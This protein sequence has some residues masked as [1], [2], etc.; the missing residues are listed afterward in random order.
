MKTRIL[1]FLSLVLCT[2]YISFAQDLYPTSDKSTGKYG[3]KIKDQIEWVLPPVYAKASHFDN[4]LAIVSDGQSEFAIN[5]HGERVSPKFKSLRKTIGINPTPYWGQDSTGI[6]KIY[7]AKFEPL[8]DKSFQ[9]LAAL[10]GN[11][12]RFKADNG[13]YGCMDY[14]GNELVP[15]IYKEI[16][17]ENYYY[18][19]GYKKCDK[20]GLE[21]DSFEFLEV[22]DENDQYGAITLDNQI[23]IPLKYKSGYNVKYKAAKRYYSKTIK[24]Y[25]LSPAKTAIDTKIRQA[26]EQIKASDREL[27]ALYPAD[28]PAVEKTVVKSIGESY[29]FFKGEKQ[30]SESYDNIGENAGFYFVEAYGKMGI[31]NAIG[32]KIIPC[33]YDLIDIWNPQ[34]KN[35]I[36]LVKKDDKY[37]L[38]DAEGK[39]LTKYDCDMISSPT[40]GT[41]LA[42]AQDLYWLINPYGRIVSPR[43]YQYIDNYSTEGKIYAELYGY[44]TE[45][46][47]D[48]K[49]VSPILK[50]IFDEAYNIP[51]S[52]D[53]QAKYDKYTLCAAL[54]DG[55]RTGYRALSLNNIGALFEDLGDTDKAMTYYTQARDLGN[56]TARKNVRRIRTDRALDALQQVGDA[57]SQAAQ[58]IDTSNTYANLQPTEM[59]YGT[60][61]SET[62]TS[63][64][65]ST[66]KKRQQNDELSKQSRY[67]MTSYRTD[68][69]T[70]TGW[71]DQLRDM[72]LN[73][74][75]FTHLSHDQFCRTVKDIQRRMKNLREKIVKNGG[76]RGK[77]TLEDWNPC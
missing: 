6:Y 29:A 64:S 46:T 36:F 3:Y 44:K 45:L 51:M 31:C 34:D 50:Q 5:T 59:D 2:A 14:M 61:T 39:D 40:N 73:P 38:F 20:D 9:E 75:R 19:I 76:T 8:C 72:K 12:F 7:N 68:S 58:T 4:R 74:E 1:T 28:L 37:R 16:T 22:C 56:E 23:L 63:S 48:G 13:L 18:G 24:P 27:T 15:P 32:D 66:G 69:W 21:S 53:L 26:V 71:E 55:N 52:G 30:V 42:I 47:K 70:Y 43:G 62:G 57:L 41:G 35:T 17:P 33:E 11:I 25:L 10:K 49:E 60:S 77:S 65:G 54:D 67:M